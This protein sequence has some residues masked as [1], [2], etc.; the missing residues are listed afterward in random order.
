MTAQRI[1]NT[2][3]RLQFFVATNAYDERLHHDII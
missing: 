2:Y 3:D 1:C